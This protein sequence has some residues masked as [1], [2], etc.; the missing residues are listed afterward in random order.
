MIAMATVT[1]GRTWE[2]EC[3]CDAWKDPGICNAGE[4][5]ENGITPEPE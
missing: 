3:A 5:Q 2:N 4:Q 1:A